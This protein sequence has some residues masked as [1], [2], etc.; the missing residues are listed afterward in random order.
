MTIAL[1]RA[2]IDNDPAAL[3]YAAMLTEPNNTELLAARLNEVGASNQTLTPTW[4]DT[5]E[6][7]AVLVG[8][9]IEA[10]TQAKRDELTML[11]STTRIKTGSAT[12]RTTFAGIFGAATT[13]RANLIALTTRSASR[14]EAL[15]GEGT[16][17]S[18]NDVGLA[19]ELEA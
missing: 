6:V 7:L 16:R 18:A 17:I 2:E 14:A 4:T 15:W 9:E 12:L 19:L 5:T 11:T 8:A 13:S 3:G 1:L 10:L